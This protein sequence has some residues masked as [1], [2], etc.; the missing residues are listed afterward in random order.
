[1]YVEDSKKLVSKQDTTTS[2]GAFVITALE[3]Y[4]D[5][6]CEVWKRTVDTATKYLLSP[7]GM[8]FGSLVLNYLLPVS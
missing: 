7:K 2:Y 1:M 3:P 8:Q 6:V 5:A 4:K